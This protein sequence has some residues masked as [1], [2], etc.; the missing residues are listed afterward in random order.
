MQLLDAAVQRADTASNGRKRVLLALRQ[1][2]A[3]PG[4]QRRLPP[5]VL[6]THKH[7]AVLI[8]L[9]TCGKVIHAILLPPSGMR[10]EPACGRRGV[11]LCGAQEALEPLQ[12]GLPVPHPHWPLGLN[13]QQTI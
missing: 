12:P 13:R 1:V 2:Y 3:W 6:A 4:N 8:V 5:K 9:I 7:G 11:V 10:P